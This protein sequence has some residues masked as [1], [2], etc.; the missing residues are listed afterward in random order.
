MP[1]TVV[2]SNREPV[3]NLMYHEI[4]DWFQI[5][6]YYIRVHREDWRMTTDWIILAM[7]M[8]LL[9]FSKLGNKEIKIQSCSH[10]K[11][12]F[13]QHIFLVK[14]FILDLY[15]S[16]LHCSLNEIRKFSTKYYCIF[17]TKYINAVRFILVLNHLV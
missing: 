15:D 2:I 8:L 5:I 13:T 17:F 7:H 11:G 6:N 9:Y 4:D 12:M 16:I 14:I 3:I 10:N 1:S